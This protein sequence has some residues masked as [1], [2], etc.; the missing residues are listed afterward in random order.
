MSGAAD[1][2]A[3]EGLQPFRRRL[4]E[5]DEAIAKLLGERLDICRDVAA[6]KSEHEIPMMQPDRVKL[7]RERY[8]ARGAEVGLPEE[9]TSQLFELL[10]ATTCKLEDE[11]MDEL[12]ERR[13]A[14]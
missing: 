12:A 2:G 9:F 13:S 7:V 11:L 1:A 5:I 8:L 14:A 6:Y 3:A 10:I 4:D